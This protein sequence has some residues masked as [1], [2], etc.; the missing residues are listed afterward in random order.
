VKTLDDWAKR[1]AA[2]LSA[3]QGIM[4][5]LPGPEKACALDPQVTE[6]VDCGSY[7]R[8]ALTYAAEPG[9]RVPA[10]L[11]IPKRVLAEGGRAPAV[12]CLHPTDD[13]IGHGVVA[14]LGGKAN[15]QYA[16]E[17]TERGFVT[18]APAY[19]QLAAYQ[20]DLARLG[21]ES[22]TMKAIHDNR[23][24]L[25]LLESLPFVHPGRFGAIGHSLGGH[26]SVYTAL[27]EPR[28]VVVVSSCGLDCYRDYKGGDIRGWTSSRYMPRLL[29]WKDR[30]QEL[31][32]D[33]PE[34]IAALAPRHVLI[35]ASKG[36]DNFRPDSVD[37][38]AATA[39]P[40]FALHGAADA[41]TVLHPQGGHD[42]PDSSREAA[43]R[44]IEAVLRK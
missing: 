30:L 32:V 28:V 33:F 6:E 3:A 17:L 42:F 29:Q 43:Y 37:R 7:V 21:Y 26:N 16:V 38:I 11:L 9:S 23:R 36:D 2:I 12:L 24:A 44:L 39:R 14:G 34:M 5:P 25:D 8:R 35:S 10:F 1:R 20:P 18:I 19:P 13:R 4:G 27:F 41:L 31:P 40:V 22:G 15:R